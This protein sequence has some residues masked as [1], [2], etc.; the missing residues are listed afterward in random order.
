MLLESILCFGEHPVEPGVPLP[1]AYDV[2]RLIVK[3]RN[4]GGKRDQVY[5]G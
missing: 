2:D 3:I 5:F 4:P 1:G